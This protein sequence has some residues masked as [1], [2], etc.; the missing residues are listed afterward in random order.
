MITKQSILERTQSH[1]H[2]NTQTHNVTMRCT[3][4]FNFQRWCAH[5][6][7]S[8]TIWLVSLT[9]T[10]VAAI[11]PTTPVAT[12]P[13]ATPATTICTGTIFSF[14][15]IINQGCR[16]ITTFMNYNN[17]N[18]FVHKRE[19]AF[20]V[21][22]VEARAASQGKRT[23]MNRIANQQIESHTLRPRC[24]KF[25][26]KCKCERKKCKCECK[27]CKCECKKCKCECKKIQMWV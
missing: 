26:G 18:K 15:T 10:A 20:F 1:Y 7:E 11:A 17:K 16:E 3:Q 23:R 6:C 24:P 5:A 2:I 21:T 9:R 19:T 25:V 22:L 27:I 13:A 4:E 12:S 8:A 14:K